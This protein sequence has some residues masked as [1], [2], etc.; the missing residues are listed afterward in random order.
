MTGTV[1]HLALEGGAWGI[2]ADD[3]SKLLPVNLAGEFR[4]DGLRI[5]FEAEP[6]SVLGIVQWGRTV[7]LSGVHRE[8]AAR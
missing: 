1:R 3:G 8:D 7:R 2:E 5:A 6:V 4:E